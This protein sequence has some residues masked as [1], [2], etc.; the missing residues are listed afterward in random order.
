MEWIDESSSSISEMESAIAER[1]DIFKW[2]FGRK[3]SECVR[4]GQERN[5]CCF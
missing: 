5:D 2:R 4:G 3:S 1:V